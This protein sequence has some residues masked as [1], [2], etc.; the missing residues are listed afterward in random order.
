VRRFQCTLVDQDYRLLRARLRNTC[1]FAR[2]GPLAFGNF[3]PDEHCLK[4]LVAKWSLPQRSSDAIATGVSVECSDRLLHRRARGRQAETGVMLIAIDLRLDF[5]SRARGADG[6]RS[7]PL[8]QCAVFDDAGAADSAMSSAV[9]GEL[10]LELAPHRRKDIPDRRAA[11][12]RRQK[13]ACARDS[14]PPT[15]CG[16]RALKNCP[17]S[18]TRG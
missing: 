8:T 9:R 10:F 17:P 18:T 13:G 1:S 12:S 11:P 6:R 4:P 5:G 15:R 14:R 16:G 7:A 3:Q 2:N